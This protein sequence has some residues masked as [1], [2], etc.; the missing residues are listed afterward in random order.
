VG[1]V[2]FDLGI[3]GNVAGRQA[4]DVAGGHVDFVVGA[5][6]VGDQPVG[7]FYLQRLQGAVFQLQ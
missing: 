7:G 6:Q 4:P 3:G 1:V 5:F 2:H